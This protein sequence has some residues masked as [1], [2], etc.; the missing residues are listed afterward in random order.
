M[1]FIN[2]WTRIQSV[3][4]A[5]A[6]IDPREL[7]R[8]IDDEER[9]ENRLLFIDRSRDVVDGLKED[10][11]ILRSDETGGGLLL[12]LKYAHRS[13]LYTVER[14]LSTFVDFTNGS[15]NAHR[16]FALNCIPPSSMYHDNVV[17]VAVDLT[18]ALM[19][20]GLFRH[21]QSVMY[22]S[23]KH[24]DE[25]A[26]RPDWILTYGCVLSSYPS[27][28]D[29]LIGN[30][31]VTNQA[32]DETDRDVGTPGADSVQHLRNLTDVRVCVLCK[33]LCAVVGLTD[34]KE[35][36]SKLICSC[37]VTKGP[38]TSASSMDKSTLLRATHIVRTL[39]VTKK[40]IPEGI[41]CNCKQHAQLFKGRM[42][43]LRIGLDKVNFFSRWPSLTT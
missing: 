17:D 22:S 33:L 7:V 20:Q 23:P 19:K 10:S 37:V 39:L 28:P 41:G 40:H 15:I 34:V 36:D 4:K 6:T 26:D 1:Y 8:G 3:F 2:K 38:R 11:L 16:F 25:A 32:T 21:L 31:Q 27:I 24:L 30:T 43:T 5:M 18:L 42:S 14:F 12:C 35:Q 29:N 13:T 9:E